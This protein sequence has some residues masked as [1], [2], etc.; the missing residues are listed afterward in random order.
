MFKLSVILCALDLF[1]EKTFKEH[2]KSDIFLLTG[3]PKIDA[4]GIF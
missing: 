1:S 4:S 2:S 3:V